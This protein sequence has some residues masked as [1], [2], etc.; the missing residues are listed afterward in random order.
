LDRSVLGG[1]LKLGGATYQHG[2]GLH[3]ACRATW[4]LGGKYERFTALIGID[5]SARSDNSAGSNADADL[6]IVLDGK[7]L[8]AH[9]GLHCGE[10]PQAIDLNIAGG[11]RLTIEVGFGKRGDVQD[12][13][14]IVI[15]ALIRSG[16]AVS[17]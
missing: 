3:S 8:A 1:P 16:P 10:P 4:R 5:D 15:P 17:K 13:V 2:I 11:D 14:D 7:E 9:R 6:R 12:R